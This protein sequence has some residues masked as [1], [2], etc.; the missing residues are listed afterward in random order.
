MDFKD[1]LEI[2]IN[3]C[4]V[5]AV[6]LEKG[7]FL[8]KNRDRGYKAR[9]EVLH[10]LIRGTEV[11]LW[12]DLDTDWSEGINEHGI[13]IINSSLLVKKDEKESNNVNDKKT[14]I[15]KKRHTT[16]GKRIRNALGYKTIK[17]VI[18]CLLGKKNGGQAV[19]GQT[20]VSDG[21]EIYVLEVPVRF[22]P[23]VEKIKSN[24]VVRTNHGIHHK[25]VGYIYGKKKISSHTRLD[26]AQKNLEKISKSEEILPT[27]RKKYKDDPFLN[28]YRIKNP[29]NMQTTGQ[30]LMDL[31]NLHVTIRM[32][33]KQ[34][35]FKGIKNL[36]PKG[37][38]AKID[39]TV[40]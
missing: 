29:F 15:D 1:F 34:G 9:V 4:V 21:K 7:I 16:D 23:V 38:K 26:L 2:Q 6:R 19:K 30:I 13:G 39:L 35:S 37:Y 31:K 36:L 28:P 33:K 11:L 17:D 27:L 10:Q 14:K 3:E 18:D 32:D 8:A 12:H 20:I 5:A 40:I 24:V 25:K 22:E